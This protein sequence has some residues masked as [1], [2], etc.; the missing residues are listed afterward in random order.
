M[1]NK[2][3][4]LEEELELEERYTKEAIEKLKKNI[5]KTVAE[6]A[7]HETVIG[8]GI[9]NYLYKTVEENINTAIEN[10]AK[11]KKQGARPKYY[12]IINWLLMVYKDNKQDLLA[13]LTLSAISTTL[14][15]VCSKKKNQISPIANMIGDTVCTEAYIEDFLHSNPDEVKKQMTGGLAN[16]KSNIYRRYYAYYIMRKYNYNMDKFDKKEIVALGAI[17]LDIVVKSSDCFEY[18]IPHFNPQEKNKKSKVTS[19]RITQKLLNIWKTNENFLFNYAHKFIPMIVEP[20]PWVSFYKGGYKG[21]LNNYTSLLRLREKNNKYT[22]EYIDK[23]NNAHIE[24][25]LEAVNAIQATPWHIDKNVLKVALTIINNGG[26]KAGIPRIEPNPPLPL[27]DNPTPEELKEHKKKMVNYYRKE[28]ARKSRAL[29]CMGT[30]RIAE[31]F[32]GYDRIYFPCNMD[33]RGRVYPIPSFSPQSDDLNKGLLQFSDV[34]PIENEGDLKWFYIAGANFAGIDKVSFDDRIKWVNDNHD[35][36]MRTAEDPMSMIDWWGELDCPF[37]LL[38]FCFEYKKMIEYKDAHNGSIIGWKTGMPIAFDGSCSGIQHY[39]AIL[40][41]PVGAKAVNLEPGNKPSDIYGIVAIEVN[42]MIDKDLKTGSADTYDEEKGKTI[43]GN[44]SL[45]QLWRM[46]GV[47][48]KV[49]KRPVMTLAYGAKQYGFKYQILED[50][51]EPHIGEG[52]FTE[53]NSYI[54]SAYMAKLIWKAVQKVVTKAVEGMKW[55]QDVAAIVC[56]DGNVVYWTT[57]MGL[58]VQQTYLKI[59]VEKYMMRINNIQRRFYTPKYTADI[60]NRKQRQGIAPN[61]IHSMDASH[62]QFSVM[63]AHRRGIKHY[64]M[65]HDSYGT[66]LANAGELYKI[67]RECFVTMYKTHNVLEEF[68][69]EVHKYTEDDLPPIPERGTF[70]INKVLESPYAFH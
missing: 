2:T 31:D 18:V 64:A 39:S 40:R 23:I 24:G 30:I 43:L 48:R 34:P 58:P 29:R 52:I 45:A 44:K 65:I 62:L 7:A 16:R 17:L 11:D 15:S 20:E 5:D 49:T 59:K 27:L 70:D 12:N 35:N 14:S 46:Y 69:K 51:V 10:I 47:N 60:A 67:I 21:L 56:K 3:P 41:D 32:A 6:G 50:T 55:L 66:T 19:I 38:Q 68:A 1:E 25:T 4:T 53:D 26:D 61:F 63:T 54:L 33:F 57:P 42:K 9:T 13:L 37:E 36:I 22:A 28:S 8:R